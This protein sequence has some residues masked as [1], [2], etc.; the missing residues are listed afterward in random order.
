MGELEKYGILSLVSATVLCVVLAFTRRGPLEEPEDPVRPPPAPRVLPLRARIG[1]AS[2]PPRAT[3]EAISQEPAPGPRADPEVASEP[4][5]QTP[6]ALTSARSESQRTI[7]STRKAPAPSRARPQEGPLIHVVEPGET[8]SEI[9]LAE[10]GSARRW[11]EIAALNGIRRPE[12]LRAGMRL[13]IPRERRAEAGPPRPLE[14]QGSGR[15]RHRVVEGDTLWS[16]AERYLGDGSRWRE[17]LEA[18]R[19]R[20]VDPGDLPVG[21]WLVLP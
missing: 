15:R 13:E 18:N 7:G 4:P 2:E 11:P 8:L 17:V 9:A 10:L 19:E 1:A 6:A 12:D 3:V 16:I 14:A 20:I 21:I 5:V